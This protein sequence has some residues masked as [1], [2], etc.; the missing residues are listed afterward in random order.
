MYYLRFLRARLIQEGNTHYEDKSIKLLTKNKL[1]QVY[2]NVFN[3]DSENDYLRKKQK[4]IKV[5]LGK[6]SRIKITHKKKYYNYLKSNEWKSIRLDL[7]EIRGEK[8]ERC[9]SVNNLQV[10]HLTYDNL[11]NEAPED[12]EILCRS[13]HKKEHNIK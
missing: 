3:T 4:G 2:K 12:L 11:F 9:A 10:H 1:K 8:C 7:L 13:C 6:T 5:F